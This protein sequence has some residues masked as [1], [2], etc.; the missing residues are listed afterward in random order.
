MCN[1]TNRF[2]QSILHNILLI[3]TNE[4]LENRITQYINYN[5]WPHT[6]FSITILL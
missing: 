4:I 3:N 1:N 6:L 2:L 5:K